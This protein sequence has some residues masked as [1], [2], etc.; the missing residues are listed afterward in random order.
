M[1]CRVHL[2]KNLPMEQ[3]EQETWAVTQSAIVHA[4]APL[5]TE[6]RFFLR[7]SAVKLAQVMIRMQISPAHPVFRCHFSE[8]G[9]G[10]GRV[11]QAIAEPV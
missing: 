2:H 9:M 4:G 7:Y 6:W 3:P 1:P 10:Q 11:W 5:H 8:D